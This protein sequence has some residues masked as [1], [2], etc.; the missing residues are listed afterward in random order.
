[1]FSVTCLE[2][3]LQVHPLH[4]TES[5]KYKGDILTAGDTRTALSWVLTPCSYVDT[6]KAQNGRRNS[7]VGIETGYGL[8]DQGSIPGS[9]IFFFSTA[10]R[11]ALWSNQPPN[12]W[13]KQEVKLSLCLTN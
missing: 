9:K 5:F 10:S 7:T 6:H 1:M 11:Q 12:Q 3:Q 13:V 8:G 2:A 4:E